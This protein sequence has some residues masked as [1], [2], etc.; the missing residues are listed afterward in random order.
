MAAASSEYVRPTSRMAVPP[1]A[2]ASAAPPTPASRIQLSVRIIQPK[3]IM[4]PKDR[5]STSGLLST[6]VNDTE[7]DRCICF[8]GS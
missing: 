3:P 4:A 5:V 8:R 7:F 6:R 2:K 1:R